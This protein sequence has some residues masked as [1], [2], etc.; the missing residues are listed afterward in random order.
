M[1]K[2]L[3]W[4]GLEVLHR[5]RPKIRHCY[6]QIE[7]DGSVVLKSP[8]ISEAEA[9]RVIEGRGEWI[10][11]KLREHG[12]RTRLE[13]RLGEEVS[14]LG[15]MHRIADNS[16]FAELRQALGRLRSDT[17]EALQ[18]CYDAFYRER[19]EQHVTRRFSHF[20]PLCG[21]KASVL[22]FRKMKSRWGSCSSRGV[23]TI[24]TMVMRLPEAVIDYII[25][26]ELSH[27]H[28]M[29][30][31]RAFYR[32]VARVM[33]DYRERIAMLKGYRLGL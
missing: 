16:E 19:A 1:D 31:S 18:R 5:I 6:I 20:E 17:E 7:R 3:R 14:Y 27:L 24:N 26:H 4:N 11:R 12:G 2:R 33:P 32:E 21:R 25:V 28:H 13:H 29:N 30:H 10:V 23:I 8:R 15:R 9:L 22:R